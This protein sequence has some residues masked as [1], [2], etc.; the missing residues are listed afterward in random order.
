M[1]NALKTLF[2]N[3]ADAI[4]AKTGDTATMKPAEFPEKIAA[5]DTGSGDEGYDYHVSV[6][7]AFEIS[8]DGSSPTVECPSFLEYNDDGG[9]LVFTAVSNGTGTIRLYDSDTLI[10]EYSV[11]VGTSG[12][13]VAGAVTVSFCNY[14]GTEL[15]SRQVFIGDD[16][17]DPITQGRMETPTRENTAQNT[18]VYSGW[19]LTAGG[20]VSSS[21]LTNLTEDRTVYAAYTASARYYTARFYDGDTL[22]VTRSVAYGAQAVPPDTA[23]DGYTFVAWEP[24]DLTIT[25]DTDFYGSW[26]EKVSFSGSTWAKISEMCENGEAAA[27]FA[28][29]DT[30]T[31]ASADGTVTYQVRIVGMGLDTK[32]DGSGKA[33]ITVVLTKT[34]N[35]AVA[36]ETFSGPWSSSGFRT[37]CRGTIYESLPSDL[38][39]VIKTVTKRTQYKYEG[40]NRETTLEETLFIPSLYEL[41]DYSVN[42]YT[43]DGIEYPGFD[44]P[45]EREFSSFYGGTNYNW[46]TRTTQ[47]KDTYYITGAGYY[48]SMSNSGLM[49]LIPCFCI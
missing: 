37:L 22:M 38:Q 8:Y 14:D 48:V 16:C 13:S 23:K 21:A 36:V 40:V 3:I 10:G 34:G 31:F 5:I 11:K 32:S 9:I 29:G 39:A 28:V 25:Q 18:F 17:P 43:D 47:N 2:Q 1:S 19:S 7:E 42:S 26:I 24:S 6:G 45:A 27:N 44:T 49:G 30:K 15:F 4:R 41:V 33:G 35:A 46:A 12:G 20:A